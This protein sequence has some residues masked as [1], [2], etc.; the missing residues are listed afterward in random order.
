[1]Q[2]E[3]NA[4]SLSGLELTDDQLEDVAG[5]AVIVLFACGFVIGFVGA[6]LVD[7]ATS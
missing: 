6:A 3:F 2:T 7:L 5:G 4:L 1:M